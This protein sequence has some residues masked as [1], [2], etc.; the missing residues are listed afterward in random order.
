VLQSGAGPADPFEVRP[1][2]FD[3]GRS[4]RFTLDSEVRQVSEHTQDDAR[5]R[6]ERHGNLRNAFLGITLVLVIGTVVAPAL[7]AIPLL[8]PAMACFTIT[9]WHHVLYRKGQREFG[10]VVEPA[11]Q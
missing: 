6:W 7:Y 4:I 3:P 1:S 11:A 5:K 10:E 2:G 9:A 8:I